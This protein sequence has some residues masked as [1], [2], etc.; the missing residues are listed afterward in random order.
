[1]RFIPG[2]ANGLEHQRFASGVDGHLGP[3]HLDMLHRCPLNA[4]YGFA[5]PS[6]AGIA[7]H[8]VDRNFHTFI[9]MLARNFR[10]QPGL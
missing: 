4:F 9:M 3:T 1:M 6:N 10:S 5:Y 8:P 7:M 2:L